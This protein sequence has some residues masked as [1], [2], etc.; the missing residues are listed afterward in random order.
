MSLDSQVIPPAPPE[1][2]ASRRSVP[3]W[4]FV[5]LFALL[6]WAMV[7]F[8]QRSAW[9]DKLVYA[10]YRS[11]DD[12]MKYQPKGDHITEV[13]LFG[14]LKF[15]PNCGICHG[16]DGAGKPGVAPPMVG[17]EWVQGPVNRLIRIPQNGFTGPFH[18]KG[19]V[20]NQPPGQ[21]P[22][23]GLALKDDELAAVLTYIRNS[24]SNKAPEVTPE[25]VRRVRAVPEV[26]TRA[27]PWTEQELNSVQ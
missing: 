5:L 23:M 9:T 24:W 14:K 16:L 17:S 7:Y 19:E 8:D 18:L 11:F 21:M 15:E 13:M 26:S 25:D 22:A 10:P 6:Y 1:P 2:R 27:V 4:L 12:L 3:V 20:Y